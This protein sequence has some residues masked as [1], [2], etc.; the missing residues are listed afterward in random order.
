M[1]TS[2]HS[3]SVLPASTERQLM[4]LTLPSDVT[5]ERQSPSSASMEDMLP[6]A[7]SSFASPTAADDRV[8]V[9]RCEY[10]QC[11]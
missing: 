3:S 9:M 4:T 6:E 1:D 10:D 8:N 5:M 7:S 11:V 2:V